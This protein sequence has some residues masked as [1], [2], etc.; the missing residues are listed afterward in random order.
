MDNLY[1]LASNPL[2]GVPFAIVLTFIVLWAQRKRQPDSNAY[3]IRTS[4]YVGVLV[5]FFIYFAKPL[6][7]ADE[8]MNVG[9]M[10]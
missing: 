7:Q 10:P 5:Y 4:L 8:I 9:P 1:T 3:L 6:S 2:Y